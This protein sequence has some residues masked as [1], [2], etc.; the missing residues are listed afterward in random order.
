[1]LK[2]PLP[3]PCRLPGRIIRI[4]GLP[5]A[6]TECPIYKSK[7]PLPTS[8]TKKLVDKGIKGNWS[9]NT[10]H[11]KAAANWLS[12]LGMGISLDLSQFLFPASGRHRAGH[13]GHA[14]KLPGGWSAM[15]MCR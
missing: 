7:I 2:K 4:S 3:L 5:T 14:W 12:A 10:I 13:A 15:F 11:A 1:M 8:S 9:A 6:L